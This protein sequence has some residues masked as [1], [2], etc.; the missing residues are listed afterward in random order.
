M[1]KKIKVDDLSSEIMKYLKDYIEN[2]DE[3]V[4]ETVD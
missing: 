4:K 3:E 1:S 2:I